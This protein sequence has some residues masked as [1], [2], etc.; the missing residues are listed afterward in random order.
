MNPTAGN[1][2]LEAVNE[3]GGHWQVRIT[4]SSF[5]IGRLESCE[6]CLNDPNVSRQHARIDFAADGH[7]VLQD[8]GSKNGTFV[9]YQRLDA[10]HRLNDGDIVHFGQMTFRLQYRET[11]AETPAVPIGDA[12]GTM[13][14]AAV[15]LSKT[16]AAQEE[17]RSLL[18]LLR[19]HAVTPWFQPIVHAAHGSSTVAFELLGRG[20]HPDL[21]V[22]P[23]ALLRIAHGI[24]RTVELSD[25]FR[26]TGVQRALGFK[27]P[28]VFFNTMPAEM[29]LELLRRLLSELRELAP[30]LPLVMEVHEQ[31]IA[32]IG[33]MR[34]L[35]Q[36]L[37]ELRMR[38]A[39]DD[40]GAGQA[41]LVE[42]MDVP[43][44]VL[45][46]DI[47]LI[48]DIHLKPPKVQELVR[49]L[50]KM[51][52]AL[53]VHTLAEGVETTD[54]AQFCREAGFELIQGYLYGKPTP[55]P[56]AVATAET[57]C[58]PPP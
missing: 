5:V 49:S 32:D 9:N 10:P 20:A 21:P 43:P 26:K 23:V 4:G 55:D 6:L 40:F 53:G 1:W 35:R 36:L 17:E 11:A 38:L 12:S 15:E 41:R 16:F 37:T 24:G 42:L 44:D 56:L 13:V 46:F 45:K 8:C 57:A 39:Y 3:S 22:S 7:P 25:L 54:E 48:R 51:T 28:C 58:P 27:L 18:D 33:L 52:S 50:V 19:T 30:Q 2:F 47:A 34:E 14:R 29:S 31:A